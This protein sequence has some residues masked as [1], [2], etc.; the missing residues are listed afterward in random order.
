[1]FKSFEAVTR[2]KTQNN[3]ELLNQTKNYSHQKEKCVHKSVLFL[4]E[5]S[6]N[7]LERNHSNS[8]IKKKETSKP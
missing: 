1:M 7:A 2:N 4:C 5:I 6:T 3:V 8:D